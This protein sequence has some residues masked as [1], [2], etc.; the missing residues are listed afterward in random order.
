MLA[1]SVLGLRL[2]MPGDG[3]KPSSSTERRASD[4]LAQRFAPGFN[5]R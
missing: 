3:T 2:G 1:V 5:S 4:D